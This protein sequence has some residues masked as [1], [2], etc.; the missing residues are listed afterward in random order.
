MYRTSRTTI[1]IGWSIIWT[2]YADG[3]LPPTLHSTQPRF[4]VILNLPVSLPGSVYMNSVTYAPLHQGSQHPMRF[5]LNFWTSALHRSPLEVLVMCTVEPSMVQWFASNVCGT[6]FPIMRRTPECVIDVVSSPI[7]H[8]PRRPQMLCREAVAW[9]CLTH[10]NVVPFLGVVATSFQL[11]SVLMP[12]GTLSDYIKGHPD[13][14][15][16]GL[17]GSLLIPSP[18]H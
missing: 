14:D 10:P 8:H 13:A 6:A 9:K 17:V 4:L 1:W 3:F 11:V 16:V 15:R 12:D 18:P 2:R 7:L 5:R